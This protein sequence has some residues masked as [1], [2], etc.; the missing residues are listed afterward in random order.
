VY[1]QL[2]VDDDDDDDDDVESI[3]GNSTSQEVALLA[4]VGCC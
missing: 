2:G 3:A 1:L 4:L